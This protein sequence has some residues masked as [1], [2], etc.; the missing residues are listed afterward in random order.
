MNKICK[1]VLLTMLSVLMIV[2]SVITGY[3]TDSTITYKG[4]DAGFE[5]KPGSDYTSTDLFDGFKNIIPGMS[6]TDEVTIINDSKNSDYIRVYMRAEVHDEEGNPLTYNE[7]FESLDGKDQA[8]IADERD[9]T[10]ATMQEFLSKLAMRIYNGDK[11]IYEASPDQAGALIDNVLLG[12]LDRG[13]SLKLRV[14]LDIPVELDNKYANRVGEVDWVFKI[15]EGNYS[16]GPRYRELTVHKVWDDNGYPDRPSS[17]DV[18]LYKNGGEYTTV[19]LDKSNNWTY[20]FDKLN[21]AYRWEIRESV[22]EGYDVA[23][24]ANGSDEI[25]II[26]HMDYEKEEE[27]PVEPVD[28]TVT[29]V[30]DDENNKNNI[31]PEKAYAR[32]YNGSTAVETVELSEKNNWTYT[33]RGLDGKGEWS[34]METYI[35]DGYVASYET[36]DNTVIITNTDKLL[37]TGQMN[38]PVPVLGGLGAMLM[39]AGIFSLKRKKANEE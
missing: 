37:Q 36:D 3:A 35:P 10:V 33:W 19:T 31:R 25:F 11:L 32:L 39:I 28:I 7:A 8:N 20:T 26:N 22:P 15:E 21:N 17:V 30:W 6:L 23:Y 12:R 1:T 29:K 13:K 24:K 4:R 2:S 9:E 5:F 38:W 18:T 14:E 16:S 34:V 27:I